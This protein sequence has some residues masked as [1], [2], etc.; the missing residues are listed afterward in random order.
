[1][2]QS[3]IYRL[4][5]TASGVALICVLTGLMGAVSVV[6]LGTGAGM[7]ISRRA[8]ANANQPPSFSQFYPWLV[9]TAF[10]AAAVIS[11][12]P[13]INLPALTLGLT[14]FSPVFGMM[15]YLLETA[16]AEI[17]RLRSS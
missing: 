10:F 7:L 16:I 14:I 12:M 15:V 8:V 17:A 1:M 9:C 3:R 5:L 6:V 11:L 2:N 4:L 13:L